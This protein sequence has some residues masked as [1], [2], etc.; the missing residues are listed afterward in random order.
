MDFLVPL[1]LPRPGLQDVQFCSWGQSDRERTSPP[2]SLDGSEG[3]RMSKCSVSS[4]HRDAVVLVGGLLESENHRLGSTSA[5]QTGKRTWVEREQGQ[6]EQRGR[7]RGCRA[8][9]PICKRLLQAID[10]DGYSGLVT[11]RHCWGAFHPS[12]RFAL[13]TT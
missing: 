3:K 4:W 1:A 11:D 9:C 13:V 5:S 12:A 7:S 2:S 10:A 6:R 8:P